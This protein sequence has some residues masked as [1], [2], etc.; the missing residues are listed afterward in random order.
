M[1]SSAIALLLH[2]SKFITVIRFL[3]HS[4]CSRVLPSASVIERSKECR[5]CLTLES[6]YGTTA[7]VHCGDSDRNSSRQC[8]HGA[9]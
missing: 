8:P 1:Q 2:I 4:N 6:G 3:F 5:I 9:R 7:K